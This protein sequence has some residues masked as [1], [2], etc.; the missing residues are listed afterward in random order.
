MQKKIDLLTHPHKEQRQW[1]Y[2]LSI[3]AITLDFS[4][5]VQAKK[6]E[7]A[8][9]ALIDDLKDHAENEEMFILPLIV[10]RFPKEA[11]IFHHDHLEI[12][13]K[14]QLL[15]DAIEKI[16]QADSQDK[17]DLAL[18]FYRGF[19]KFIGEYLLHLDDE[20]QKI[21]PILEEHFSA[22]ELL[23]VMI[24]YKTF[25]EGHHPEKVKEYIKSMAGSLNIS[26]L[27]DLFVSLKRHAPDAIFKNACDLSKAVIDPGLWVQVERQV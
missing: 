15:L 20:E 9:K 26:A 18:N 21:L 12:K 3:E 19:N 10:K 24:A 2:S 22:E 13:V 27:Q 16:N 6:Y 11:N 25:R 4:D 5:A 17:T 14:L 8:F 1:M 23:G 7:T